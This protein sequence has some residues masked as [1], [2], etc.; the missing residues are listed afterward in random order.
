MRASSG[1]Q[2]IL[3]TTPTVLALIGVNLAV[4]VFQ[5][6]WADY[7]TLEAVTYLAFSPDFFFGLLA[8]YT[9]SHPLM[10][11]VS[12]LSHAFLHGSWGHLAVNMMFALALATAVERHLGSLRLLV[13]YALCALGGA[14]AVTLIYLPR[15]EFV[16][17]VGASGAVSGLF[18]GII[19]ERPGGQLGPV[20]AFL[21]ANMLLAIAGVT[22][23][24]EARIAWE[25]HIGGF[26]IGYV[27]YP[28]LR[29]PPPPMR[30]IGL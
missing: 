7:G 11:L 8:G 16:L 24:A 5:V 15:E 25:A 28:V 10:V 30:R 22:V 27:L 20:S 21:I 29:R 12:P 26:A 1:R 6:I 23:V 14:V 4:H 19:R 18:A 17:V 9:L 3:N 13:F 2:P